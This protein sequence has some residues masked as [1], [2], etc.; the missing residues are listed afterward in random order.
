M[1]ANNGQGNIAFMIRTMIVL[2]VA[3]MVLGQGVP[4]AR[5]DVRLRVIVETDAGG[6]PDDEQSMVRFLLYSNEWDVEGIICNRP[7]AR[8]GENLNRER[9]GLGI[10]RAMIAA[11][12][13]CYPNLVKHDRR[14]PKPEALLRRT[15]PGYNDTEDGVNLIIEAMDRNDARPIW[16]CNWG[17]D[18][19]GAVS[20]LKRALDRVLNERGQE[21]Y[22]RFKSRI[23]LCSA[24]A[25]GDHTRN[26]QPPFPLWVD[27][28]RPVVD[29]KR[30]Y[31]RFSE[32][33][34]KAGGFDA[35]RDLL[36]V[37]PLGALYPTNTT[38]KQK[39][40]DSMTFLYI[41]RTGMNDP[42]H[43]GWGSWAGRYGRNE[44]EGE[45]PYYWANQPDSWRGTVHRDNSLKRWAADLQNDFRARLAW[46]VNDYA[47]ANHP[48]I[49]KL[50]SGLRRSVRAGERV[51]LDASGS[52]D[53][54]GQSIAYSWYFYP[55]AGTH[56][57]D[58]PVIQDSTAARTY[59]TAPS[60]YRPQT[61]HVILAVTDSG[62]PPITR[63]R[64]IVF[65]VKPK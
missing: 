38:H 11:Y 5:A 60:V 21:E 18:S 12:G 28:F 32:I 57:G 24:D 46:C 4:A 20:S 41:V 47:H 48:P 3:L 52:R 44:E 1:N 59:F 6:D 33:T 39:E 49:P 36:N 31:H 58:F 63:Y 62:S 13:R 45:R 35:Q 16:F 40:G 23:R 17:T 26:I 53:P 8:D 65:T 42:E 27:T 43:P 25:F 50:A 15:V 55:E 7:A 10:V 37:G 34:A 19:G 2:T 29:G 64:R 61:L 51:A 9:T 54:D 56:T 22:A 14:Y 30:W